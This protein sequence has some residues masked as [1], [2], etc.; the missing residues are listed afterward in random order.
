MMRLTLTTSQALSGC[1]SRRTKNGDVSVR[2]DVLLPK[3]YATTPNKVSRCTV[4]LF[5]NFGTRWR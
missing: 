2:G 1:F 4:P 5:L 3:P